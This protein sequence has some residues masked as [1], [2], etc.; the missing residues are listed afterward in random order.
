MQLLSITSRDSKSGRNQ[1]DNHSGGGLHFPVIQ[2]MSTHLIKNKHIYQQIRNYHKINLDHEIKHLDHQS[3]IFL[4]KTS[5]A[6]H[7]QKT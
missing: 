7:F 1:R 6:D 3:I 2:V 5:F 4:F